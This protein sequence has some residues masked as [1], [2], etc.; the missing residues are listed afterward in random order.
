PSNLDARL[1]LAEVLQHLG[2]PSLV[3]SQFDQAYAMA[4]VAK[5]LVLFK[6]GQYLIRSGRMDEAIEALAA[7]VQTEPQYRKASRVLIALQVDK[8]QAAA[9][10]T[11]RPSNIGFSETIP[12]PSAEQPLLN[13]EDIGMEVLGGDDWPPAQLP[14][15]ASPNPKL[16]WQQQLRQALDQALGRSAPDGSE[17][18]VALI[19]EPL[20]D[21][22]PLV[23]HTLS[24]LRG[25]GRSLRADRERSNI[26]VVEGAKHQNNGATTD[27][28]AG[29]LGRDEVMMDHPSQWTAGRPGVSLKTALDAL[30]DGGGTQGFNCILIIASGRCQGERFDIAS[31]LGAAKPLSVLFLHPPYHYSDLRLALA[32]S[33]PNYME[34]TAR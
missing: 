26:F 9:P 22:G 1:R 24:E 16:P 19:I 12:D 14:Q 27:Q 17:P 2:D 34:I 8:E 7:A 20:S 13:A 21:L 3:L 33:S 30:A 6:K 4:P 25:L 5:G 32:S 28:R 18:H 29:W 15:F 11:R 10:P 31:T 23:S